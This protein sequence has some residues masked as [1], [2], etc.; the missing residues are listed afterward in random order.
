MINILPVGDLIE[1]IES[2]W[3]WCKPT[4]TDDNIIIHNSSDGREFFEGSL[5][6]GQQN[7]RTQ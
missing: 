4:I 7:D 1:H 5:R 2:H 6:K 3:C